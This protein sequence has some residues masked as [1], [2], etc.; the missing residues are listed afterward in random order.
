M[1][2]MIQRVIQQ[3]FISQKEKNLVTQT[4]SAR[5]AH[6]TDS[7]RK[8]KMELL[9]EEQT[10]GDVGDCLVQLGDLRVEG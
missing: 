4:L 9:E 2:E 3:G 8:L 1:N 6:L 7:I 10:L 5:K